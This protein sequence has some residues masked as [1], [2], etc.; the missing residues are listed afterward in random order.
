MC[1]I[2]GDLAG[3]VLTSTCAPAAPGSYTAGQECTNDGVSYSGHLCSTGHCDLMPWP[4]SAWYCGTLCSRES[5]CPPPTEC[6]IVLYSPSED[7]DTVPFDPGF[8][9]NLHDTVTACFTPLSPGGTFAVGQV[10]GANSQCRSNKCLGDPDV[11]SNYCMGYCVSDADCPGAMTCQLS[12]MPLSS[13]W[14]L[15]TQIGSQPPAP[16]IGTLV[17]LCR[18]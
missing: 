16:T 6:G 7:P 9:A 2:T 8:T 4:A 18:Y 14:L 15:E 13:D 12:V 17:R 3:G 10:C 1:N 11:G 5:D